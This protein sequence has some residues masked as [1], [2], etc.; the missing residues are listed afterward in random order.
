MHSLDI[1]A[2]CNQVHNLFC[3]GYFQAMK[4]AW[5]RIALLRPG[6]SFTKQF[7]RISPYRTSIYSKSYS[8]KHTPGVTTQHK[9]QNSK[10]YYIDREHTQFF[11]Q[12]FWSVE[13]V[14]CSVWVRS[15][16]RLYPQNNEYFY[17]THICCVT[18]IES[19]LHP[20]W[21]HVIPCKHRC[22]MLACCSHKVLAILSCSCILESLN[23]Y[24]VHVDKKLPKLIYLHFHEDPPSIRLH[25]SY[26]TLWH[27]IAYL[28]KKKKV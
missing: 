28:W 2:I 12:L 14:L 10:L 18:V 20:Q 19:L 15:Q 25:C 17:S 13:Y 27:F 4:R 3:S 1:V 11:H 8:V 9:T 6:V 26:S 5:H 23:K 7:Q 21:A 24:K 16:F 22:S